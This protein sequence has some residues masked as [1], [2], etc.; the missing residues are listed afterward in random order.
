MKFEG[1][2]EQFESKI[3]Q[4][5]LYDDVSREMQMALM[6]EIAMNSDS[7]NEKNDKVQEWIDNNAIEFRL[8]FNSLYDESRTFVYEWQDLD[9]REELLSR[10]KNRIHDVKKFPERYKRFEQYDIAA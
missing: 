1:Q 9:Q 6:M 5:E 2:P 10:I 4:H 3:L 8:A 7:G